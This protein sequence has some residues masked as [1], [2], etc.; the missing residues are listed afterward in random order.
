MPLPGT[1]RKPQRSS[2]R[3]QAVR[4]AELDQVAAAGNARMAS[5]AADRVSLRERLAELERRTTALEQQVVALQDK[6]AGF[7]PLNLDNPKP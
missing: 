5:S 7:K 6:V 2:A 3:A 1:R 4:A